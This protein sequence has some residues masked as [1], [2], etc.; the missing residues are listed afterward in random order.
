MVFSDT[1]NALA[2]SVV[3]NPQTVRSVNAICASCGRAGWQQVKI[4][5]KHVVLQDGVLHR[6]FGEP[7]FHAL[8]GREFG[9]D[10]V[11]LGEKA[12]VTPQPVDRLVAADIDQPGA[13]ICRDAFARPLNERRGESILHSVFGEFEI[14]EQADQRGQHAATLVAEQQ[15]D[16]IRLFFRQS[17]ARDDGFAHDCGFAHDRELG[18]PPRP[19]PARR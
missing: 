5:P 6:V 11:A 18:D 3:V 13:R 12:H 15:L 1:R 19:L 17:F 2:I 4:E 8:V 16:P 7:F 9:F 10:L 14:A